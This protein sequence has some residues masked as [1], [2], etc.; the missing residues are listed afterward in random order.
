MQTELTKSKLSPTNFAGKVDGKDVKMYV[1]SNKNG[2][3][4]T[5]INYGAKIVSLSDVYKRQ[6][7]YRPI[8]IITTA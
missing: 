2:L 3:E 1:L 4:A 5:V 6:S 7:R 8:P